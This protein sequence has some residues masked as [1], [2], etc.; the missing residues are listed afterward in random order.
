MSD[1]RKYLDD[2]H[3]G[4]IKKGLGI[5]CTE[6][7]NVLRYKQGQFNIINGLDNVGK[8]AWIMWYFLCLAE[9]HGIT[10]TIWSGENKSG[11]L[12]RQMIEWLTGRKLKDLSISEVYQ[13]EL[14]LSELFKFIP[15]DKMYKNKDLYQI[16]IDNNSKCL[17]ID[18]FT[19]MDRE[20]THKGNYDFLNETRQFCNKENITCYVNTHPNSEAARRIHGDGQELAGYAMPPS[21]AQTEGGQPFANRPDDFITIHRYVGHEL[22]Q[23]NTLIYTRKIKD[24]ETGGR[25]TPIDAPVSFDFNNGLGFTNGGYNPLKKES[26]IVHEI[27]KPIAS[28]EE[29]ADT[30]FTDAL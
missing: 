21:K 6:L 1:I 26:T 3:A 18:P 19:G 29:F 2:Y 8:T 11:M 12:I 30:S 25:V 27:F 10:F 4:R 14:Q 20:Y 22:H 28:N 17:L 7:D 9:L 24:T 16:A 5:G 15:N 23:Y 13:Y